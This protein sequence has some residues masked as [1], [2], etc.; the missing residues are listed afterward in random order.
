ME[1]LGSAVGAAGAA[2]G[3]AV[4]SA[5]FCWSGVGA[6]GASCARQKELSPKQR[7]STA[8]VL[9]KRFITLLCWQIV[10]NIRAL[11]T[12]VAP[13]SRLGVVIGSKAL[14]FS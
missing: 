8:N 6:A 1:G 11:E 14:I 12:V 2:A 4:W 5:G 9:K 13:A 3:A 7:A 10:D